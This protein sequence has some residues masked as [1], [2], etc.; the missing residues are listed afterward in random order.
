[1]EPAAATSTSWPSSPRPPSRASW[2][3]ATAFPA[4]WRCASRQRVPT[5]SAPLRRSTAA[6]W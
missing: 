6:V 3:S 1:M 2:F 5:G 4:R